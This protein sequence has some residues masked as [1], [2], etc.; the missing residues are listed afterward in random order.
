VLQPDTS[1][2]L[3]RSDYKTTSI[4]VDLNQVNAIDM[5]EWHKKTRE[6][7][8]RRLIQ[9]TIDVKKL[10]NLVSKINI[11]LKNERIINIVNVTR[12]KYLENKMIT[13]SNPAK[14]SENIKI[15][16][17]KRILKCKSKDSSK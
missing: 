1:K 17:E 2:V 16:M 14:R 15:I 11:H 13:L 12:V 9:S 8:S 3:E 6:M 4:H 10:Q 5:V 7:V